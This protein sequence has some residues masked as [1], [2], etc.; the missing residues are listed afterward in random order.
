MWRSSW[1]KPPLPSSAPIIFAILEGRGNTVCSK[2]LPLF[3]TCVFVCDLFWF[4][5]VLFRFL[6]GL[7]G[8]CCV[9]SRRRR[10]SLWVSEQGWSVAE[11]QEALPF[12]DAWW[13]G[14][15]PNLDFIF[16]RVLHSQDACLFLLPLAL[17]IFS[18][19]LLFCF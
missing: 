5:A 2:V 19:V 17:L 13:V 1:V 8:R 14:S 7:R 12:S 15:A 18:T 16:G 10:T 3:C 11:Y 4:M 6:L 9:R